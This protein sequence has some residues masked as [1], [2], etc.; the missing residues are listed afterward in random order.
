MRFRSM[1]PI[2]CVLLLAGAVRLHADE[3]NKQ[4]T[5][6]INAPMEIPG[7]VLEPGTYVFKLAESPS[8]RNIV[9]IFNNDGT[10]LITTLLTVSDYR[11]HPTGKTVMTF[12]ERA[13]GSPEALKAW[14]YPGDLY[15]Q[16]FVYPKARAMQLA[17][18]NNQNVPSMPAG[19][20]QEK[21]ALQQAPVK[22][23]TPQGNEVE[24]AKAMPP[25]P[26]Q[27]AQANPP[28][29]ASQPVQPRHNALPRTASHHALPRTASNEPLIL[30]AGL[31]SLGAA[32]AFRASWKHA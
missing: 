20:A 1:L 27:Q 31:I 25:K 13:A 26:P 14:F 29:Q 6:E 5:V 18:Q 32:L 9:E 15:G 28:A 21:G 2:C 3:W 22:A 12:E 8:D 23:A 24:V 19:T 30:L 7:R 10:H 4:T 17:K 11:L 16:E